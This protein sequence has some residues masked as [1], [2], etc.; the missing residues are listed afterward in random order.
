MLRPTIRKPTM[1]LSLKRCLT[2]VLASLLVAACS[3]AADN[4][5]HAE[6]QAAAETAI[7]PQWGGPNAARYSPLSEINRHNVD[8]LEVA[9]T[10]H[11]GD[12][13]DGSGDWTYSSVQVTPLVVN[14]T[15]Y[16][17]T[18]F[19]RVFALD[20][21]S[22]KERWSFDP[23]IR[24]KKGGY[25]PAVCRGVSYWQAAQP[26]GEAC[27]K[28]IL[29]G[30]R[31][32][33]L[34]ALDADTG[35]LCDDFGE[36]GRV[37]LRPALKA[38]EAWHYYPTSPPVVIGN[39]VAVG[40]LIVDN[41]DTDMP[42][43]V[44]R[45]FDVRSGESAW[46]WEPVS[47]DYRNKHPLPDGRQFYPGSPNVWAPMSADSERGLILVPTGNPS[48]DLYAG[49]RNGLDDMGSSV[50]ALDAQ[51]GKLVWN[52]QMVHTDVWDF[53]TGSQPSLLQIPALAE[54]RPAIL[55]P[56]KMGHIFLLDRETGEPLFPVE[57]RP[58]PKSDIP[59]EAL[60]P[61]QPFPTHPQPIHPAMALNEDNVDG[62]LWFEK[63][64]CREA[65]KGLRSEG[66]FTPPSFEGSVNYPSNTGGTTWGSAAIDPVRGL[67][68]VNQMHMATVTQLIPR[69]QYDAEPRQ[70]VFPLEYFPM[71]GT[72]YGAARWALQSKLGAPCNPRPW[73]SMTAVDLISGET[74]WQIPLGNTRDLAPWPI[75][76]NTGVPNAGG[77]LA[78]AGGLVFFGGTTDR[79]LRAF[80]S[81]TGE[82]LWRTSLPYTGNAV[83]I[84]Y[85][86]KPGSDQYLVLAAGG[87]GWST[88]GDA[89]IAWKLKKD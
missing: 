75:H 19:G 67:A 82:Q 89:L 44:V 34:I 10:H 23:E 22:G 31:D 52:F 11:S 85:R 14:E 46:L 56:T 29:Y 17:C 65:V 2:A 24:N 83:P 3:G 57:E 72:P 37:S 66:I 88:A 62:L 26:S 79:Y 68:F 9:W 49:E 84:S 21:E 74:L 51:T 59:G 61:T 54:G 13:S 38:H 33:E 64:A 87:H 39:I 36:Q 73:G 6:P 53:D 45:A 80:D 78:T 42:S 77:P 18:P 43:G 27:E 25:Y 55:Q 60:S 7:W 8:E 15:L 28:R 86:L 5:L 48:P 69:E 63:A 81:E 35:K 70:T 50:V 4:N 20:P 47:E 30:S 12:F 16:Y 76:L 1:K 40:S 41:L 58:V 71:R 32:A